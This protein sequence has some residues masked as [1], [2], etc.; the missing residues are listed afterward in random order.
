MRPKRNYF[1]EKPPNRR[2]NFYVRRSNHPLFEE[3]IHQNIEPGSKELA[4]ELG[5]EPP[6]FNVVNPDGI[7]VKD[8]HTAELITNVMNHLIRNSLDHGIEATSER[9]KQGKDLSG[10]INILI[11]KTCDERIRIQFQDDGKGLNVSK[12]RERMQDHV[13]NIDSLS[14]I[15][16][17]NHIFQ[18]G[19]STAA[20]VSSTSGRGVGM[21]A[22]K[23]FL[24]ENNSDIEL[25]LHDGE[26]IGSYRPFSLD[27]DLALKQ[28][29]SE[30]QQKKVF[31]GVS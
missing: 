27:I 15:D 19:F 21:D 3:F 22:V 12:I 1:K 20:Q 23:G 11:T 30:K 9:A 6:N 10:N 8:Q 2:P 31:L 16:V 5:K 18:P 26:P 4:V 28:K 29:T 14:C 13:E 7:R 25:V 17:A 24:Q